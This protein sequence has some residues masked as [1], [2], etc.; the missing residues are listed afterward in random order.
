MFI[1]DRIENSN[2]ENIAIEELH[3]LIVKYE[4]GSICHAIWS[5]NSAKEQMSRATTKP[6]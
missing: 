2:R 4:D 1:K 6:T 5:I 3:T